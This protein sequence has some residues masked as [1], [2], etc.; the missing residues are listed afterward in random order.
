VYCR[1]EHRPFYGRRPR[2][3]SKSSHSGP[4]HHSAYST[5]SRNTGAEGLESG[6]NSARCLRRTPKH[7]GDLCGR[8]RHRRAGNRREIVDY[9]FKVVTPSPVPSSCVTFGRSDSAQFLGAGLSRARIAGATGHRN[10]RGDRSVA[11]WPCGVARATCL[12]I[13][14]RLVL[15]L[16]VGLRDRW[17]CRARASAGDL[18]GSSWLEGARPQPR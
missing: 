4:S 7:D 13:S 17:P 9:F 5:I 11:R 14:R 18:N 12:L 16:C 2:Q 15:G 3:Y 10:S 1:A 8:G 6:L